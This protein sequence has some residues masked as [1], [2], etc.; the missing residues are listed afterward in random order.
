MAERP[1]SPHL[2]VYRFAYTMTLSILH[3][4]TGVAL[5]VCLLGLIVWLVG[6]SLGPDAYA[7]LLPAL[8]SWPIGVLIALALIALVYHFCNGL[9]HLGWDMGLG[10]ERPQARGTA[11]L[12]VIGTVLL[13]AACVYF[14]FRGWGHT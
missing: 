14:L 12:V 13:G 10:F 11:R 9:R 3:R 6:I 4:I 8:H 2:S 5:A 1:L 7:M